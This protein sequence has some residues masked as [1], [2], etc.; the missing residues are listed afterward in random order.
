[1]TAVV[2]TIQPATASVL[3]EITGAPA[4]AVTITRSDVNGS[5]LVRLRAGQ[6]P[7]A[8]AL[9]IVDYEP[10]LTGLVRYD[11]VDATPATTTASLPT[12]L[13]LATTV[14]GSTYLPQYVVTPLKLTGY[15]AGRESAT[16]LH[17]ILE[18]EDYLPTYGPMRYRRGTL[19]AW[20]ATYSA[21]R[22]LDELCRRRGEPLVLRQP[23]HAG[24]DMYFTPTNSRVYPATEGATSWLVAI[25]YAE[26]GWPSGPLLGAA[27][28]TCAS[29]AAYGTCAQVKADFAT[30]ADLVAGP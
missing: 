8:G 2:L 23:T 22:A 5:R 15:E 29:V 20:F 1:M 17:E 14:L 7:I 13:N 27:G 30:C 11:V 4:G 10:A 28:W 25:E 24:L 26:V 3:I 12:G 6:V 9:S 21:A 18:R 19:T 16:I